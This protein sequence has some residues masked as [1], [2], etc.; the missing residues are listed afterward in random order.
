MYEKPDISVVTFEL[1]DVVTSSLGIGDGTNLPS[2]PG[3][4]NGV[5]DVGQEKWN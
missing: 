1:Q 2:T 5:I 3:T 4:N